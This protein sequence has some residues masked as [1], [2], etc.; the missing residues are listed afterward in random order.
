MRG[1]AGWKRAPLWLGLALVLAAGAPLTSPRPVPRPE[2]GPEI[3]PEI[4]PAHPEARAEA[5]GLETILRDIFRPPALEAAV[6]EALA[7]SPRPAPRP[8]SGPASQP[9]AAP[10]PD[11][12]APRDGSVCGVRGIRGVAIAPVP[13]KLPGCGI[14]QP[15]RVSAVAGVSL[16]QPSVM[17]CTTAEALNDWVENG[18]LPEIGRRGGGAASLRVIAGYSCRPRN[19]KPGARISE[20]GKGRAIDISGV[21][22]QNGDFLGVL[23]GWPTRR[24]GRILRALFRAACGPFGTV[25]GPDADRFHKN[26]FHLDTAR[27][28]GG[29]YCR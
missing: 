2:V 29:P 27:Y 16:S 8:A 14:A 7:R 13:A 20:H 24:E 23:E 4:G 21:V 5:A 19:N 17:D 12:R 26:H 22:L 28:R 15:V 3:G 10:A 11:P 1:A 18:V 9:Q 6:A 25:L